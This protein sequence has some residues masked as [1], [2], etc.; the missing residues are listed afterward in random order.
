LQ[1]KLCG[2]TNLE[3]A[4]LCLEA[5]ADYLGLIFVEDSK[6]ACLD[7]DL[8]RE[9]V[10]YTHDFAKQAVAVFQN[11]PEELV[12][13][14]IHYT[15]ADFAQYHGE[16]SVAYCNDLNTP[17]V[18]VLDTDMIGAEGYLKLP[19]CKGLLIEPPKPL[20]FI[21][22]LSALNVSVLPFEKICFLAG[23]LSAKDV[24]HVMR[25]YP[26]CVLDIASG[27]ESTAGKK[28]PV[29]VRELFEALERSL[30]VVK[31]SHP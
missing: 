12:K 19:S 29:L 7:L 1:V 23:R 14:I 10:K 6:R 25:L 26:D 30:T 21:D 27:V 31:D 24:E 13:Q 15:Q 5:G 28:D 20:A 22:T 16:E 8:A 9:I 3:D 11:H 2:I 4:Q 17:F 18:K